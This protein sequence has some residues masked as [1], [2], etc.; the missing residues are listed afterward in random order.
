ML[1]AGK[2]FLDP[3]KLLSQ[4]QNFAQPSEVAVPM[5]LLRS[6]VVLHARGLINSL[7]IQHNLDWIWPYWVEC[8]YD[9]RNEAFIPRSFSLTQINLTHRN[10]TALGVPDGTEFP[11]VDPRGLVTPYYDGWS[12]DV[13][14]IPE[15]GE[16]LIPSRSPNVSQKLV[17]DDN[18]CVI[19]ES[20]LDQLKLQ[21]KAQVI[22]SAQAPVCQVKITGSAS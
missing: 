14:I 12:I 8:Q 18:L 3:I 10:W 13:W 1:R 21:L 11:L 7:A 9:P 16:P 17:L 2:G 15:E 4:L 19:T 20:S 22:G 5:E 6:G